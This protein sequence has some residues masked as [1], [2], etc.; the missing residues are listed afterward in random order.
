MGPHQWCLVIASAMILVPSQS[1]ATSLGFAGY[2]AGSNCVAI[3]DWGCELAAGTTFGPS[4]GWLVGTAPGAG[5][6][7]F[8]SN[9]S[10]GTIDFVPNTW[11][12]WNTQY[13]ANP[14]IDLAGTNLGEISTTINGLTAGWT[15]T[16]TFDYSY[17]PDDNPHESGKSASALVTMTN[18]GTTW[19]DGYT[20]GPFGC[21]A[22]NADLW[23]SQIVAP[24]APSW[25]SFS[26]T[27]TP[28]G[29]EG[30]LAS[31]VLTLAAE[32]DRF[33]GVV[34]ADDVQYTR[35]PPNPVNV[36]E[37]LS[38]GLVA[39]GLVLIGFRRIRRS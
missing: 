34:I 16:L 14:V 8:A 17:N 37:P 9:S 4:G 13:T 39:A 20:L 23:D 21:D 30:S 22:A 3:R 10:L 31:V 29:S 28:E 33:Q 19:G 1:K 24:H 32:G 15:Y 7:L 11:F 6:N 26:Q 36:P 25:Y 38:L 2:V 27:F 5:P 35:F 18:A 12:T